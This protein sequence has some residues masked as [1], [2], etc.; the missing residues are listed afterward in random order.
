MGFEAGMIYDTQELKSENELN[1]FFISTGKRNIIKA[2]EYTFIG[3][4]ED[5]DLYNLGFGD[6]DIGSD[7]INDSINTNNRD[8]RIVFNTVLNT[9]PTFFTNYPDS[10]L[11]I[12]GSDSKPKFKEDCSKQCR[13]RC[14]ENCRKFNQRIRIYTSYIN[15]N[16]EK[17]NTTYQFFGDIDEAHGQL[18]KNDYVPGKEYISVLLIKRKE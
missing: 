8:G 3:K 5:K 14:G 13:K 18:I 1:L 15:L 4:Y 2:I 7:T 12:R 16:F 17:L 6:Y 9:I 11:F 10:M